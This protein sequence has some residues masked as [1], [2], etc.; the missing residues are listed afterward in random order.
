M[1]SKKTT[2]TAIIL[3]DADKWDDWF[4]SIRRLALGANIWVHINPDTVEVPLVEPT[5]PD[6]SQVKAGATTFADLSAA[7][8]G[9]WNRLNQRYADQETKYGR[10]CKA[11][12][13]LVAVGC[14]IYLL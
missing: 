14:T 6:Y 1:E 2:T 11:I 7:E 4:A 12:N 5:I 10:K 3:T 8:Q 9:E 13:E